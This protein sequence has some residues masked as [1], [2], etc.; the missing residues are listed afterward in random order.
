MVERVFDILLFLFYHEILKEGFLIYEQNLSTMDHGT[1][2][3]KIY[4]S[5]R[6]ANESND[7]REFWFPFGVEGS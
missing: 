5:W 1:I 3:V 2:K 6:V 4:L 7:N